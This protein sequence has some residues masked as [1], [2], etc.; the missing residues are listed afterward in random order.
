ME[1][2]A[3][4]CF[5]FAMSLYLVAMVLYVYHF[6]AKRALFSWYATFATGSGFI[7]HTAAIALHGVANNQIPIVGAFNSLSLA[8]WVLV[9]IYFIVEHIVKLKLYGA[10]LLPLAFVSMAMAQISLGDGEGIALSKD[11]VEQLDSWRVAMHV[12]LI[13]VANAGFAVAA[14][15]SALNLVV[16]GQLKRLKSTS[17]IRRLPSLTQ[18]QVLARRAIMLAFPVYTAGILLGII[19]AIEFG[20]EYWWFDPRVML[21]GVVWAIFGSY[22]MLHYRR[23]ASGRTLAWLALA[24]LVVVIVLAVLARTLPA[25]FHIFGL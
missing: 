17:L 11:A 23:R 25:G 21:S 22:L 6:V 5:W 2:A 4:V 14:A 1:Q 9:L 12:A 7:A 8:A 19:R 3:L 13:M 15:A 10:V 18:T 20:L 24:G 16:G